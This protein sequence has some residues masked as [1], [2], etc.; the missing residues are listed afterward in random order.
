MRSKKSK[1]H[2]IEL[3]IFGNDFDDDYIQY[4]VFNAAYCHD[5]LFYWFHHETFMIIGER[6]KFGN[7]KE[8]FRNFL[9][10]LQASLVNLLIAQLPLRLCTCLHFVLNSWLS[11]TKDKRLISLLSPDFSAKI[12]FRT[13]PN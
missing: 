12:S 5:M 7:S 2:S 6:F 11:Q 9:S 8:H 13:N 10:W 1:T 4:S 3:S